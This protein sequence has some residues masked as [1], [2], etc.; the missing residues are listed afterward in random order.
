VP[1]FVLGGGGVVEVSGVEPVPLGLVPLD[2]PVEVSLPG[3]V[4][5]PVEGLRGS[6]PS[7]PGTAALEPV[8][9]LSPDAP[10]SPASVLPV[11]PVVV[12]VLPVPPIPLVPLVPVP[13]VPPLC[14]NALPASIASATPTMIRFIPVPPLKTAKAAKRRPWPEVRHAG[15]RRHATTAGPHAP[16]AGERRGRHLAGVGQ[17]PARSAAS[18]AGM[19]CR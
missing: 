18:V 17:G 14:A 1:G 19:P 10:V 6:I 4:D 13:V 2:V 8:V 15:G 16:V 5:V 3:A 11:L 12:P 9:P 7:V